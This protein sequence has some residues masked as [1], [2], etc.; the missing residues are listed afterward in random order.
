M[1]PNEDEQWHASQRGELHVVFAAPVQADACG[2]LTIHLPDQGTTRLQ[3]HTDHT[4][5]INTIS[6]RWVL[7]GD[8]SLELEV[9]QGNKVV[10]ERIWFS[11][12]NLRL[13]CTLEEFS[14][15]APGRASF[16]S[17]I[18]RVQRPA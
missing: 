13:R 9:K 3:F 16:S 10:R 6:G 1:E 8:G 11:K 18:R 12:P 2:E 5:R 4:V 14:D 15:G 7:C 17:E